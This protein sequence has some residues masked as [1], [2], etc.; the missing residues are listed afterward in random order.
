MT[1]GAI[2]NDQL[3]L[4]LG[5]PAPRAGVE[6]ISIGR[7]VVTV[8]FVRHRRARRYVLRVL[9]DGTVRVT[10]PRSGDRSHAL[11]FLRRE[12]RWV[13]LQRYAAARNAG[14][15]LFRGE[16]LPL[17]AGAGPSAGTV[18]VGTE[19][20]QIRTGES[21]KQA[22]SRHLRVLASRE[23]RERLLALVDR[24]RLVVKR[25]T[26]RNQQTRWGSCS[27]EGAIA[28]NWRLVQM[29]DSVRDYIL[30]HELMH[31]CERNHS[32]RFWTLVERAC[33]DHRIARRWLKAH[34][35]EL[36]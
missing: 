29:P 1:H 3:T 31:L 13:D 7:R 11:A 23:L 35:G 26:I 24:L 5:K 34:E 10:V 18:H 16:L 28:L 33:P 27:P 25:V 20:V 36:L 2:A 4:P 8:R 22:A 9:P 12:L 17:R 15:I 21:A 30:I 19:C 6:S 14:A 32:R